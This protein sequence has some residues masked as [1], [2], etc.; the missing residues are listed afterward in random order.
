MRIPSRSRMTASRSAP[1]RDAYSRS[2]IVTRPASANAAT[3]VT[4][5]STVT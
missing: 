3:T 2:V 4:S 5:D 1:L